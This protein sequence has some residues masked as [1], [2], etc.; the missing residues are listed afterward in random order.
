MTIIVFAEACSALMLSRRGRNFAGVFGLGRTR[1]F[2]V[3][4]TYSASAVF[5]EMRPTRMGQK[6]TRAE[7]LITVMCVSSWSTST[8][9]ALKPPA[10]VPRT[11]TILSSVCDLPIFAGSRA[12]ANRR[13]ASV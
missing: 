13:P 10:I 12:T 5:T 11:S 7:P 4:S 8:R 2:T 9:S 6:F 1:F 3:I